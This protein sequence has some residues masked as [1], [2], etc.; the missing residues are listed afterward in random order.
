MWSVYLICNMITILQ[1][2]ADPERVQINGKTSLGL[3]IISEEVIAHVQSCG[4]LDED[5]V[6]TVWRAEAKDLYVTQILVLNR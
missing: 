5:N 2:P 4:S 1:Q 3:R 6:C